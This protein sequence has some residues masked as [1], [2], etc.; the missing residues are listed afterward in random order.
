MNEPCFREGRLDFFNS[1][2]I[3]YIQNTKLLYNSKY[4]MQTQTHFNN[5]RI[6]RDFKDSSTNK[7]VKIVCYKNDQEKTLQVVS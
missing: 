6:E 4:N 3:N 1:S 7:K 5:I 2:S